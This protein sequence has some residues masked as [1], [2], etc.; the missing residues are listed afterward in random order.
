MCY[1]GL[2]ARHQPLDR[3]Y[4]SREKVMGCEGKC[5]LAWRHSVRENE[6]MVGYSSVGLHLPRLTPP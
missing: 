4:L 2:A 6:R 1:R 5:M 3:F